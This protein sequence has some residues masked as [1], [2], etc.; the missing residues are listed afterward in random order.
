MSFINKMMAAIRPE[1]SS[2]NISE[3]PKHNPVSANVPDG[4]IKKPAR[5]VKRVGLAYGGSPSKRSYTFKDADYNLDEIA[6]AIDTEGYFRRSK[7]K[8][9]E[10]I[11]R[12]G[13]RIS[14]K[15]A[16]AVAYVKRRL[17]QIAQ[18]TGIPTRLFLEDI[19]Q[20]LV[21]YFNCVIVKVR[22]NNNSGGFVRKDISGKTLQPV[23]GYFVQDITSMKVAKQDNGEI[24]KYK[25]EIPGVTRR[26]EWKPEDVVHMYMS[27]KVGLTFGTPMIVPV[28]DDI[29]ALRRMEENIEILI[30]QHAVPLYQ[31]TIGSDDLPA[32]DED[33]QYAR[34]TVNEMPPNGMIVTPHTH[35]IT[36]IGAEGRAVRAEGYLNYFKARVFA[37]LGMSAVSFGE[38]NTANR[39]TALTIDKNVQ[40]TSKKFQHIIKLFFDEFIIKELLLEGGF[41]WDVSESDYLVELFIPE[42]DI[43]TKVKHE[44]HHLELFQGNG[45]TAEEFRGEIGREPF[46]DEEWMDTHWEKIGKE[47]AIIQA[48]D[49]PFTDRSGNISSGAPTKP[50]EGSS[51]GG[52]TRSPGSPG[53]SNK[54]QPA[55]QYGQKHSADRPANDL[56]ESDEH[57][58]PLLNRLNLHTFNRNS[59][60]T[61]A[62]IRSDVSEY[63]KQRYIVGNHNLTEFSPDEL[64]MYYNLGR[65]K[66]AGDALHYLRDAYNIGVGDAYNDVEMLL[67]EQLVS[68]VHEIKTYIDTTSKKLIRDLQHRVNSTIR[69]NTDLVDLL[70]DVNMA[71]NVME[72]RVRFFARSHVMKS[73]NIGYVR[74]LKATGLEEVRLCTECMDA[75]CLTHPQA[76][77]LTVDTIT[78]SDL[79]PFHPNCYCHPKVIKGGA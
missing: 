46:T 1:S 8:F 64:S 62:I 16:K 37:G 5:K 24:I 26:P 3:A 39:G 58:Y 73:Y 30:F 2:V 61:Y 45:I 15:D 7:D 25:Q 42:I 60:T 38:G 59:L 12:N 44:N 10:Q 13:Y 79:P 23:A 22:N 74:A 77:D 33:I 43:D 28:L 34:A 72:Y 17:N 50:G 71:F 65:E 56:L 76:I 11:W 6:A 29:R 18:V 67:R 63:L 40:D 32:E 48:I 35:G 19:T 14:G 20:Q 78:Y 75:K 31:Y 66:L 21:P 57:T 47:K 9:V 4:K 27:R 36:A 41:E 70:I 54:D 69:K 51:T 49:E 52:M 68:D 53:V 55:N